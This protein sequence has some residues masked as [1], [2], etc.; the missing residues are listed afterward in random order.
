MEQYAAPHYDKASISGIAK[1]DLTYSFWQGFS[2]FLAHENKITNS[3]LCDNE[4]EKNT[5][6]R[7]KFEILWLFEEKESKTEADIK[8]IAVKNKELVSL[9]K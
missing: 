7:R 4:K 5:R 6:E 2:R 1:S 8:H 3:F 9:G